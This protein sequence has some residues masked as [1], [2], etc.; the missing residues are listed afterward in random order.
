MSRDEQRLGV[1]LIAVF[2]CVC[3]LYRWWSL[4][5]FPA[6]IILELVIE[7]II[8]RVEKTEGKETREYAVA[9]MTIILVAALV[10]LVPKVIIAAYEETVSEERT[11]MVITQNA[12]FSRE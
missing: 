9:W 8:G 1:L 2:V 6:A 11:S 4:A 12:V 5:V 3:I 7:W 10:V